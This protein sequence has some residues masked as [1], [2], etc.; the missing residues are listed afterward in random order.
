MSGSV[1]C[2]VVGVVAF[3]YAAGLLTALTT[4]AQRIFWHLGDFELRYS[5]PEVEVEDKEGRRVVFAR[6]TSLR[7]HGE[8]SRVPSAS[9]VCGHPVLALKGSSRQHGCRH[10][11]RAAQA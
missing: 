4:V 6:L 10:S 11:T 3:C 2:I 7:F 9:M 8:V 1:N 5:K